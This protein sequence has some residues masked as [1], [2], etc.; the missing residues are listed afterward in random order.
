MV[1]LLVECRTIRFVCREFGGDYSSKEDD[2]G[3]RGTSLCSSH[4]GEPERLSH[5][6]APDRV[7][8]RQAEVR[9]ATGLA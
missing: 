9:A 7:K 2:L 6:Q 1:R 4:Q 3:D 8:P 5:L